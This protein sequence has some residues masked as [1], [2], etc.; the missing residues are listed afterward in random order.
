[1]EHVPEFCVV[2]VKLES[3][4]GNA[5]IHGRES[6]NFPC[7]SI[8]ISEYF[9]IWVVTARPPAR[10]VAIHSRTLTQF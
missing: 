10:V 2:L 9:Y 1:M 3:R 7:M 4:E 8:L 6:P 5:G